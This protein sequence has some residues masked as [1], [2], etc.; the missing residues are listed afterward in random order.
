M[1]ISTY[2][3]L[4]LEEKRKELIRHILDLD[5]DGINV[6]WAKIFGLSISIRVKTS[7]NDKG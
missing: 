6:L 4:R 7:S 1:A 2:E 3:T 5:A